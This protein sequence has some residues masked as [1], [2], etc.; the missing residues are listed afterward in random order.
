MKGSVSAALILM[1]FLLSLLLLS[2]S[3]VDAREIPLIR[4]SS[5]TQV[6]TEVY[7]SKTGASNYSAESKDEYSKLDSPRCDPST[8]EY[9][10]ADGIPSCSEL[11]RLMSPEGRT[12]RTFD[13]VRVTR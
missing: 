12:L 1:L 13:Q 11:D 3:S 7:S 9:S 5:H 8:D 6:P 2:S 10:T 4:N